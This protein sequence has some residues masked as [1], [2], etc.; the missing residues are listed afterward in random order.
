IFLFFLTRIIKTYSAIFCLCRQGYGQD[1]SPL[2]RSSLGTLISAKY[3][4]YDLKSAD[5]N[6]VRFVEYK[7]VIFKRHLS[8]SERDPAA[9][10]SDDFVENRDQI[11][12]KFEEFKKKYKIE[13]DRALITWSGKSVKDMA[14]KIDRKLLDE[15]DSAFRLY[16]RF[17]HPSIIGDREYLNFENDILKLSS[18][19]SFIGIVPNLKRAVNYL[20]DFLFIF[21]DLFSLGRKQ[22]IND[23]VSKSASIFNSEK[24][25]NELPFEK[26]S[27]NLT[28][29]NLDKILVQFDME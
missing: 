23:L 19:P 7:W 9:K 15:Y 13:S 22:K 2:L 26:S 1:T 5:K 16:S 11:L 28:K 6:A 10:E 21:D 14:K 12:A 20:C 17:S 24:F 4:L 27:L 8:E 29:E 25:K 3:I 18:L